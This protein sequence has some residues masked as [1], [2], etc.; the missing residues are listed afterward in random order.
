MK[1]PVRHFEYWSDSLDDSLFTLYEMG[2]DRFPRG[3]IRAAGYRYNPHEY[4]PAI[5]NDPRFYGRLIGLGRSNYSRKGYA[6]IEAFAQYHFGKRINVVRRL[7]PPDQIECFIRE[8][9]A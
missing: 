8:V 7:D 2:I 1:N 5:A 9:L 3:L 6:S 4:A